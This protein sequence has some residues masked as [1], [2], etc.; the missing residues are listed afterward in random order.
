MWRLAAA[1]L[2]LSATAL[3]QE[4]QGKPAPTVRLTGRIVTDLGAPV[5]GAAVSIP[6]LSNGSVLSDADG[7]FEFPRVPPGTYTFNAEKIGY[8][9]N[10]G[11]S[12]LR[13]PISV[14]VRAGEV[15]RPV[16]IAFLRTGAVIG[17]IV[18]EF[19]DPVQQLEVHALGRTADRLTG[20][21]VTLMVGI[22]DITDD[23]GEFRLYGLPPGDYIVR[24]TTVLPVEPGALSLSRS[25]VG[26]FETLP[27]YFPGTID[28]G[29]AQPVSLLPGQEA[30]AGFA[31]RRARAL[32]IS[33]VVI[34]SPGAPAAGRTLSLTTASS[35]RS[36]PVA[37]DGRFTVEGVTPGDYQL[38]VRSGR[39]AG[40]GSI[41]VSV[42]D[43]DVSGLVITTRP[44]VTIRGR[45][46][47]DPPS[48]GPPS[49][50]LTLA[51]REQTDLA[52]MFSDLVRVEPDG[53]FTAES[54]A[55]H[56]FFQSTGNW[57]ITG[58]T[59]GGDD[60]SDS[61]I[62]LAGKQAVEGIRVTVT[63]RLTTVTGLVISDRGDRIGDHPVVLMR[64]DAP[65][66]PVRLL[67]RA[68][69]TDTD[70]RF[71]TRGLQRGSYVA[72]AVESDAAALDPEFL[73]RL[74]SAGQRFTLQDGQAVT[75]DLRPVAG[76][77]GRASGLTCRAADGGGVITS[78]RG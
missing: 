74:R 24:A 43:A 50:T 54:S 15:P 22:S 10:R 57:V 17:R 78:R 44:P 76:P 31:W 69:R 23:R 62:D 33:G 36:M 51:R 35:L 70:G 77:P 26:P 21:P 39:G 4:P 38:H 66:M 30:S 65:E 41:A 8:A 19:G 56:V 16:T 29:A 72:A 18:D 7:Y 73:E 6:P 61:G 75:L 60:V 46:R 67:V 11:G 13:S 32:R 20:R 34:D 47:F 27:M 63:N 58:V 42:G 2:V 68:L 59:L 52:S 9:L 12:A 55:S 5:A 14:T 64:V 25:V 49:V 37:A 53:Q 71:E 3:A 1:G 48:A 28:L 40:A 45:V